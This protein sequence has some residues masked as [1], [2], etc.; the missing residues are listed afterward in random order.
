MLETYSARQLKKMLGEP[1][2]REPEF[3]WKCGCRAVPSG[4]ADAFTL[5]PCE[6]DD[7]RFISG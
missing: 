7:G 3:I 2:T 6:N 4:E 5:K 1:E